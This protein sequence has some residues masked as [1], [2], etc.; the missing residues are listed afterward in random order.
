[1]T[2]KLQVSKRE[3]R[4]R[5][6]RTKLRK[7]GKALGVVYGYKVDSTPIVF[8]EMDLRKILRDHGDNALIELHFD[9]NKI[10]TLVHGSETDPFTNFYQHVEF[11]AVKMDE[12]TEVET[13][14][15]LVGD[16]KGV[17]EGGYLAQSLY[18]VTVAA[19]PANIP[20]RI[21][22]DVSDLEIGD[23]VTVADLPEDKSY[24]IV[25]EPDMHIASV[26]EPVAEE[27]EEATESE[28]GST[29]EASEE[30]SEETEESTE[31]KE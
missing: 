10:N 4:P 2:N 21:E 14:I 27:E 16:A 19:T 15:V 20:E 28:E 7:E 22:L 31:D 17:K 9:G 6:L 8:D 30:S 23:S 11:M 29:E 25:S 24:T 12:E 1:M 3:L 13:D 5:S 18:K 26:N